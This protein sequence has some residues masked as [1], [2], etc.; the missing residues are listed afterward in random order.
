MKSH[1]WSLQRNQSLTPNK[2]VLWWER[3]NATRI[4]SCL[5][6]TG[7]A[8]TAISFQCSFPTR[9]T[10]HRKCLKNSTWGSQM[11]PPT[12]WYENG[13]SNDYLQNRWVCTINCFLFIT[14]I[15]NPKA[16]WGAQ[17]FTESTVGFPWRL[18]TLGHEISVWV[19]NRVRKKYSCWGWHPHRQG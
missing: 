8:H 17:H 16:N 9:G 19:R 6:I 2:P 13:I 3:N 10:Q 12:D 14:G 4:C 7:L 1:K 5:V 15:K 11:S 18:G